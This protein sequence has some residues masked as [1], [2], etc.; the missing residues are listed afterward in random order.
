[1]IRFAWPLVVVMLAASACGDDPLET[2]PS[3][4]TELPVS[5]SF[6]EILTVNGAR[7]HTFVTPRSG[8]VTATLGILT[9]PVEGD[10]V[11]SYEVRLSLALGTWNGTAC[12]II[13]ASDLATPGTQIVGFASNQGTLCV[14]VSDVGQMVEPL[15]YLIRVTHP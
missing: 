12:Q 6:N 13:I 3:P 10:P 2:G 15:K 5:E 14:R 7:T 8:T 4:E 1:M 11:P 9:L